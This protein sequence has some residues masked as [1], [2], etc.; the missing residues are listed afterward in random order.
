MLIF[1]A[2]EVIPAFTSQPALLPL[3]SVKLPFISETTGTFISDRY[4][5]CSFPLRFHL[6]QKI[7]QLVAAQK[8]MTDQPRSAETLPCS[9]CHW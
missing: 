8:Q 6:R 1:M 7:F 9:Q 2:V 5:K 4:S 3:F